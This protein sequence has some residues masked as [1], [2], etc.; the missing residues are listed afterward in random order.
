M[1]EHLA[2]YVGCFC[3]VKTMDNDLLL[4]GKIRAVLD[5]DGQAL[6]IV[7]SDGEEMPSAAFGIPV[8]INVFSNKHGYLG[9][10][11]KIYIA[12]NS[13][14]RINEI[15][16]FGD[17][18]RREYFRIKTHSNAEVIGPDKTN[19][20]RTFKCVVT[21]ISLSGLLIA[22]S[23]EDC[24][25]Q[26]GTE[27]EVKGLRVGEGQEVFNVACTVRRIDEHRALG[28]LYGCQFLNLGRRESD[29]LCQE[30]FAKQRLDIQRRRGRI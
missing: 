2:N 24:Y 21:S 1:N 17:N 6:E 8:K 9:L 10:G 4:L 26:K 29:R 25:F 12:H 30:I 28:K 19:T 11:G 27:L 22:V 18:E 23:D 13:F 16:S 7:S 20:I 15:T 5:D 14:W 3:E